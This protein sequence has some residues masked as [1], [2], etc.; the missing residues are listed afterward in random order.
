EDSLCLFYAKHVPFVEG[1]G[2]IL[3]GV[4]R[5]KAMS[6][7]MEFRREGSGMRGMVWERPLQHSIRPRGSDGFLM[8][9]Y[10]MLER[11]EA[12]P[13]LDLRPYIA[14]APEERWDEFS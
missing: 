9:Y 4:G 8:P 5:I 10:E 11:S 6:P 7:L 13:S 14:N 12:D 2:H 1:T 3:I